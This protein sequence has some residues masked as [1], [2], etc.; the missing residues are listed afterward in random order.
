MNSTNEFREPTWLR[1]RLLIVATALA[2]TITGG[3]MNN[4]DPAET[5]P[6]RDFDES[7]AWTRMEEA[8]AKAIA[9]LPDFPGFEERR[10]LELSCTRN[11]EADKDY[12]QFELT[13]AFSAEDSATDL[14]HEEYVSLLRE[15]WT[16]AGYDV[17][18]DETYGQSPVFHDLEAR[19]PDGINYWLTAANYTSLTVQSGCVKKSGGAS[20]CPPPLGGVTLENDIA[21]RQ[22]CGGAYDEPAPESEAIDPFASDSES[23]S[24]G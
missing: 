2:T 8:A 12:V 4:G 3:C 18:R 7:T 11:G 1:H 15:R 20:E 14:V 10:L 13:Y 5:P 23:P 16:D 22:A 9:D 19:R 21:G 17:H 6:E 24:G